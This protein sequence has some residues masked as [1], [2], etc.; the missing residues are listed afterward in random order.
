M[1]IAQ[2][3]RPGTLRVVRYHRSIWI[4]ALVV[5]DKEERSVAA[6]V[7]DPNVI[8]N[9]HPGAMEYQSPNVSVCGQETA[10]SED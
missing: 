2:R 3:Y 4:M 1:P 9:E 7:V 5:N 10:I 8:P 6:Q